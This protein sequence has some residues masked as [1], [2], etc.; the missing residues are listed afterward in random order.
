MDRYIYRYIRDIEILQ[1]YM[2]LKCNLGIEL[3]KEGD[4]FCFNLQAGGFISCG[5]SLFYYTILSIQYS[6]VV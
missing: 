4:F 1:L 6:R 5:L 3:L 2:H